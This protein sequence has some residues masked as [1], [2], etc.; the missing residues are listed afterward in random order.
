MY[1]FGGAV[2]AIDSQIN[3]YIHAKGRATAVGRPIEPAQGGAITLS[4]VVRA[5]RFGFRFGHWVMP[6]VKVVVPLAI[7]FFTLDVFGRF[8]GRAGAIPADP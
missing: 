4:T 1:Q 8:G 5:R 3:D 6:R 2:G 7:P